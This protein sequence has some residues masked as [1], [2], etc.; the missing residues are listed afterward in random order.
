MKVE[1]FF[2][3]FVLIENFLLTFAGN[4][5]KRQGFLK[6]IKYLK[7]KNLL[8][9]DTLIE[10]NFIWQ[11]RNKIANS[12]SGEQ[13]ISLEIFDLLARLKQKFGI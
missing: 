13:E 7:S 10:L 8:P 6:L 12:P 9:K 2:K 1:N 11:T 4:F 3:E 5:D